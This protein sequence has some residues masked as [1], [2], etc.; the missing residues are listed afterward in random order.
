MQ[1]NARRIRVP[2]RAGDE[3][4]EGKRWLS[5]VERAQEAVRTAEHRRDETVREALEHGLGVRAV[6]KA[7][8]ID[9]ATVSRR[10]GS[11]AREGE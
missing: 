9:K 4:P 10:Y 6:S 1:R 8:G 7:L 3:T 2:R 11:H 5:R